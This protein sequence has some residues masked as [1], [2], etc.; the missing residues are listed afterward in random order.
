[1][2]QPLA[3]LN[4]LRAFEAAARLGSFTLAAKELHAQGRRSSWGRIA[5]HP[6]L[7]FARNYVARGGFRQGTPGLI[8]SMLNS[9]YVLLKFAKLWELQQQTRTAG[10]PSSSDR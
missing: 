4:S 7:A 10:T 5:I 6:P 3:S 2:A 8:V 1:M 9:Y